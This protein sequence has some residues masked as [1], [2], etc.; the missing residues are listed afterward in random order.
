MPEWP[1]R[2]RKWEDLTDN[3]KSWEDYR[4]AIYA[5]MVE[6]MDTAVGKVLKS[7]R[8]H[9]LE[10]KTIVCFMSASIRTGRRISSPP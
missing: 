2:Q 8:D 6:S 5:A 1:G 3:E 7:I 10:S 4:M 9:G